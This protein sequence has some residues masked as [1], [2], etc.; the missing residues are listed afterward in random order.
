MPERIGA[1]CNSVLQRVAVCCRVLQRVHV[2]GISMSMAGA[3]CARRES[4]GTVPSV[5]V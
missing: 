3:L 1:V 2:P 5:C 4:G